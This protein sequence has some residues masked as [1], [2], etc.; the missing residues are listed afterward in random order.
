MGINSSLMLK[1]K[2]NPHRII[3]LIQNKKEIKDYTYATLFF[4]VSSFFTFF[5]IRP[6]VLTAFTLKEKVKELNQ[7]D[8]NLEKN[9]GNVINL[10]SQMMELREEL[11]LI[12]IALPSKPSIRNLVDFIDK[13]ASEEG[14][15]INN[16]SI[17]AID[18]INKKEALN[19]FD[20]LLEATADYLSGKKF[21]EKIFN[22]RRLI[23]IKKLNISKLNKEST[24]SSNL[25]FEIIFETYYL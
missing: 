15:V 7:I 6:S 10:Q 1:S 8:V 19:K 16:L 5:V 9:I 22:S 18:M 3:R 21:I 4:L 25:R 2:I 13:S 14:V 23:D 12:N 11:S 17:S 20:I 24:E